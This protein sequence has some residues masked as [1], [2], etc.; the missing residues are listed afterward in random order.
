MSNY[1][2]VAVRKELLSEIEK[3]EGELEDLCGVS[4]FR[5]TEGNSCPKC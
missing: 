2:C 5:V 3:F 4:R 1:V